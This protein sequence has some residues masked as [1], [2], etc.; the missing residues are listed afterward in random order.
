MR[1]GDPEHNGDFRHQAR[2][3]DYADRR[4]SV[5]TIIGEPKPN[6][7]TTRESAPT[8]LKFAWVD[9]YAR[10]LWALRAVRPHDSVRRKSNALLLVPRITWKD[11]PPGGASIVTVTSFI[12]VSYAARA[13]QSQ[14]EANK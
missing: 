6:A 8:G 13:R 11:L 3:Y 9:R 1:D 12:S 7:F 10:E 2:Q 14:H 4:H 5:E